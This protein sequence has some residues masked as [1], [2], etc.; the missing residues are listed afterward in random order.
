M[1]NTYFKAMLRINPSKISFALSL[2]L[3][4]GLF[5]GTAN[6]QWA[7]IDPAHI[8]QDAANFLQT[9]AQYGKD[10]AQYKA[11]IEHY[12]QQLIS[13]THMNFQQLAMK[14]SYEEV[15]DSA[16]QQQ[17]AANCPSTDGSGV[18]GAVSGLLQ[19]F[20]P[21]AN[22]KILENQQ[23]ICQQI[24]LRQID[25]YNLTVRMMK[26]LEFYQSNANTLQTEAEGSNEQG[27]NAGVN[28]NIQLNATALE[29]EMKRWNSQIMADDQMISY[30]QNQQ[31][32]QAR[33]ILRGSNTVLGN[34]I[35]AGAFA[36]AFN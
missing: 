17:A 18:A 36:A 19:I 15:S 28:T 25:K 12:Q 8:A 1:I 32:V 6:A 14:N 34:V 20:T 9:A 10:V 27:A 16:A 7:V 3:V 24:Q 2:G 21:D 26:R 23:Q 30:M 5:G 22:S 29:N 33:E 35:Q 13:L 4:T 11:V 31:S